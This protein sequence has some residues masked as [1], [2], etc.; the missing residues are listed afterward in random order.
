MC[1]VV[2]DDD[3]DF[4]GFLNVLFVEV[5][6]IVINLINGILFLCLVKIEIFDLILFDWNLSGKD[7]IDIV[8]MLC[9]DVLS[10]VLVMLLILC[11]DVNDIV[12]G[13]E[14]G[15]DDYIVKFVDGCIL[16]VWIDVLM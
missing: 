11:S 13:L 10:D 14:V 3:F 16:I 7:G 5:G 1:I 4:V 9:I 2:V 12:V 15:V 6:Y 8:W